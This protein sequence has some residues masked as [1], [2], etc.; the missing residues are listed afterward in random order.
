MEPNRAE[1]RVTPTQSRRRQRGITALGFIILA[2]IFGAIGLAGLKITPLYLQKMRIQT[3]LGDIEQELQGTGKGPQGIRL[4]L[5]SR[6]YVEGIR[7]PRENVTIRQARD[8]Y[9][10]HVQQENRT[11]FVADL[12][13]VVMVDEKV[14][15]SR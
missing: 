7:V 11:P 5:E 1:Y 8:G 14:E 13:F 12:W 15:I 3:V 9:E 6:F 10:V 2:A 4:E